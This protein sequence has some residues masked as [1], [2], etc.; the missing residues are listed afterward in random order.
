M[1]EEASRKAGLTGGLRRQYRAFEELALERR[2]AESASRQQ[3]PA[4]AD[5]GRPSRCAGAV[6]RVHGAS[7]ARVRQ[8]CA[9][10]GVL[11]RFERRV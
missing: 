7:R 4:A 3:M 8:G 2:L 11:A 1:E 6:Q 9:G 10:G 5:L